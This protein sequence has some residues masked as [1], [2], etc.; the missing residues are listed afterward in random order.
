MRGRSVTFGVEV[1]EVGKKIL[2]EIGE[3]FAK[4][5][6]LD[7]M[8]SVRSKIKEGIAQSYEQEAIRK[9]KQEILYSIVKESRFEVPDGLVNMGIESMMKSY[10]QDED[11]SEEKAEDSEAGRKLDEIRANL[12]PL[13]VNI[14]KEQFIIDDI[15]KR[16]KITVGD[17]EIEEVLKS[18]AER[19]GISIDETRRR[20]AE[21]DEI[22]RWRRDILKGKVLDF[23]L[24]HADVKK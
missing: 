6:G 18:V 4:S 13:A 7:S 9:M 8:E 16:E 12:R 15:A 22:G 2:P 3:E 17:D 11:E 24:E 21:S 14:V 5:L 23:L 1:R 10:R 20:A 19:S